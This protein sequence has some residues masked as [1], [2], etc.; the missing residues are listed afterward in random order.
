[1]TYRDDLPQIIAEAYQAFVHYRLEEPIGTCDCCISPDDVKL[2]LNTPLT[3][4]SRDDFSHY[5]MAAESEDKSLVVRDMKYF[6]PRIMALLSRFQID[7]YLCNECLLLRLHCDESP[8]WPPNELA[9]VQRFAL[10]YFDLFMADVEKQPLAYNPLDGELLMFAGAGID[11]RPLLTLWQQRCVEDLSLPL[12]YQLADFV[13]TGVE[14]QDAVPQK[15]INAFS[16]PPI[17]RTVFDWLFH[18][19]TMKNLS[20]SIQY[21]L[22]VGATDDKEAIELLEMA[23]AFLSER[24]TKIASR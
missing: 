20:V 24:L 16:K 13:L 14:Y 2:L 17:D 3:E 18:T 9:L 5:F 1:M 7:H 15:L 22:N 12:L 19:E 6:L 11:I 23:Q 21:Q 10:A 4:L 8:Y